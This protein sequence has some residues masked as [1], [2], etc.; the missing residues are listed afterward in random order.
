MN[1]ERTPAM[2]AS[3]DAA[4]LAT[5]ELDARHYLDQVMA[6]VGVDG[7]VEALAQPF[8]LAKVDQHAAAVRE[9]LTAAGKPVDSISLA[10][11]ARS[12]IAVHQ[13]HGRPLPTPD[14][15]DWA[16]ADWTVLRL[17]AVCHLADA[18]GAF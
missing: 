18:A 4:Y 3:F 10:G 9:S 14:S 17:V 7:L 11:Y 5:A 8:L 1:N 6:M 2:D 13:R 15:V 12:V 16:A